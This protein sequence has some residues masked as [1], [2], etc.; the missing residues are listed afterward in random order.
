MRTNC[1]PFERNDD[2]SVRNIGGNRY[3][4]SFRSKSEWSIKSK[5]F[6]KSTKRMPVHSFR[7]MLDSRLST[8]CIRAVWHEWFCRKPD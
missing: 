8:I 7:L 1:F 2:M 6:A 5:A 4:S 3:N